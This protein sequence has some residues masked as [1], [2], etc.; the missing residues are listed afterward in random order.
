M[1]LRT[2]AFCTSSRPSTWDGRK[3]GL[4]VFPWCSS[5]DLIFGAIFELFAF[6]RVHCYVK[7]GFGSHVFNPSCV[8]RLLTWN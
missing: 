8:I 3:I 6:S 5:M 4:A 1:L 2:L 7:V